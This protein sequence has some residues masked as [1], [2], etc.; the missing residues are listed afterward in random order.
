MRS[1][2][3][4]L[5]PI[6]LASTV[7]LGGAVQMAHTHARAAAAPVTIT[8]AYQQFGAPPYWD[9]LWWQK[10]KA[11]VEKSN[12][13]ITV[14]LQPIVASES[15]YYTKVD[16]ALRSASTTPDLVREDSFLVSSDVTAGYLEPLDKYLAT[17]PEYKQQWFSSMQQITQFNGHNYGIMNGTDDRITWYNK[18]IFKKA[19]L[20]TTWQPKSWADILSAAQT[21]KKKV[22]GVI[23]INVYSGLAADEASTM[24]GYEMLL[25]GTRDAAHLYD[26]KTKKWVISSRGNQDTLAF[27]QK[28]YDPSNLLGPPNDIALT[29]TSG[30][31]VAQQ[32]LPEGKLGI[33][34]DGS[35]LSSNWGPSGAK[36]W[37]QWK[38]VLGQAKTPTEFGQA[39][40]YVTLSGGWAYSISARSKN[41][42]AAWTVLKAANSKDMLAYYDT[43][44]ANITPRKD[45]VDTKAY[46]SVPLNPFFTSLLSFAQFRPGFPAYPKIS[47]EID[48][49]MEAVM[50]GTSPQAALSTY[51]QKVTAI[52][53]ASNVEKLP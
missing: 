41:K 45:V 2:I 42:D 16:L 32:L 53:G 22:P 37:P 6:L 7:G 20:P 44:V 39:P 24:Q 38:T 13:N 27:I 11:Q 23:P 12:P 14:K 30:N 35:W 10:V 52:A 3:K 33:D 17:W 49:A 1:P 36:P 19:G 40:H 18:D 26:Y 8:V 34:L 50:T 46:S 28:I 21:I 47:V 29:A 48:R 4:S 9:Q 43:N 5:G 25:Y 31:T 51:A 15:D